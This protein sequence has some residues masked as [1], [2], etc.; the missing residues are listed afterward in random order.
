MQRWPIILF[1]GIAEVEKI[2][3]KACVRVAIIKKQLMSTEVSNLK[4]AAT[5]TNLKNSGALGLKSS[6]GTPFLEVNYLILEQDGFL[7]LEQGG[8]LIL[9]Q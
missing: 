2:N 1:Q 3:F 5:L 4:K 9:E 6:I 7:Q 8:N